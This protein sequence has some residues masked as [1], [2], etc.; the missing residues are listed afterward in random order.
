MTL[1]PVF[2]D[3][4]EHAELGQR[5]RDL[6]HHFGF[7]QR[8]LGKII[9][10]VSA[11]IQKYESGINRINAVDLHKIARALGVPLKYFFPEDVAEDVQVL[12]L[13]TLGEYRALCEIKS[14]EKRR[15]AM[16]IL[17]EIAASERDDSAEEAA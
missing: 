11:Q 1:S 6:R 14:P 4:S 8:E 17:R 9:D 7:S 16:A 3:T 13:R 5:L 2:R 15:L 12:K 10:V